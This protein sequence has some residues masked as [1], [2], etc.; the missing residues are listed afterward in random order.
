M[1]GQPPGLGKMQQL[2]PVPFSHIHFGQSF[3]FLGVA[4][5]VSNGLHRRAFRPLASLRS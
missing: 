3:T 1:R 4:Q 5:T 2:H